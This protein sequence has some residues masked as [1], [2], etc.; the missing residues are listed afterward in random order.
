MA[1][2]KKP[3]PIGEVPSLGELPDPDQIV[4]KTPKQTN[5]SSSKGT[6]KIDFKPPSSRTIGNGAGDVELGEARPPRSAP[7]NEG[8]ITVHR[9]SST[10]KRDDVVNGTPWGL[11]GAERKHQFDHV[12]AEEQLLPVKGEEVVRYASE[13]SEIHNV[14]SEMKKNQSPNSTF[15]SFFLSNDDEVMEDTPEEEAL[16]ASKVGHSPR[17]DTVQFDSVEALCYESDG[18]V[19]IMI[20]RVGHGE[21]KLVLGVKST[22]VNMHKDAFI[23]AEAQV[24]M[25][26]GEFAKRISLPVGSHPEWTVEGIFHVTM[27]MIEGKADLGDLHTIKVYV[28]NEVR[29]P[30][31]VAED[32]RTDIGCGITLPPDVSLVYGFFE[33]TKNLW[34]TDML[35]GIWFKMFPGFYHLSKSIL[36]WMVLDTIELKDETACEEESHDITCESDRYRYNYL[37]VLSG[38]FVVVAVA[39][40]MAAR[41]FIS[42]KLGGKATRELRLNIFSTMLQFTP[43]AEAEFDTGKVMKVCEMHAQDAIARSWITCFSLWEELFTGLCSFVFLSILVGFTPMDTTSLILVI[44]TA[45]TIV[46]IA[47]FTYYFTHERA[48]DLDEFAND[49]DNAISTFVADRCA[50]RPMITGFNAGHSEVRNFETVHKSYNGKSFKAAMYNHLINRGV[51]RLLPLG[52][53][54]CFVSFLGAQVIEN[55]DNLPLPAFTVLINTV[56]VFNTIVPNI[57]DDLNI[58]QKGY[59][60]IKQIAKLLNAKTRRMELKERQQRRDDIIKVYKCHPE[61]PWASDSILIYNLTYRH[62][63]Q[64]F[65]MPSISAIIDP[66]QVV[67]LVGKGSAGKTTILRVLAQHF[68]PSTGFTAFPTRWRVRLL[69]AA[70]PPFFFRGTLIE[71]LRFGN[72]VEHTDEEILAVCRLFGV[73]DHILQDDFEVSLQGANLSLSDAVLLSLCRIMLSSVDLLLISNAL[74]VLGDK[75]ASVISVLKK[76]SRDRCL[77]CLHT[78]NTKTGKHKKRKTVV[79][80]SKHETVE[81]LADHMIQVG[82]ETSHDTTL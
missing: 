36:M 12:L 27:T 47:T 67:A 16:E 53:F 81:R 15:A 26:I 80:S 13:H 62:E 49:A 21:T 68:I 35:W 37:Y 60:P 17:H 25:G 31:N 6:G 5:P 43:A 33:H 28:L 55:P 32:G 48:N 78:E 1:G 41:W 58:I 38:L 82:N 76:F 52:I 29:F 64:K 22:N 79:F 10:Y 72:V 63:G 4:S 44:C 42:L 45:P 65:T 71:N 46:V 51:I 14:E 39:D 73:S 7:T 3:S 69:D 23:P 2:G 19:D 56:S 70:N 61:M 8:R 77:D 30:A 11:L 18:Q 74:D 66:C 50:I 20:K 34:T 75:A 24:V 59:A 40:F 54:A 9:A 57:Y